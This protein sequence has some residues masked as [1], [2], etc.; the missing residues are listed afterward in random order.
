MKFWKSIIALGLFVSA[1]AWS[2]DADRYPLR[3]IDRPLI[4]PKKMW[5]ELLVQNTVIH[6]ENGSPIVDNDVLFGF[7]PYLPSY[8]ITDNLE[9]MYLPAPIFKY[10]LTHNNINPENGP[11]V[12]GLSV[13]VE[14]G[15][16]A[17][18]SSYEGTHFYSNFGVSAKKPTLHWL[19]WTGD[20]LAYCQDLNISSMEFVNGLGFQLTDRAYGKLDYGIGYLIKGGAQRLY[21]GENQFYQTGTIA[22]GENFTSNLSLNFKVSLVLGLYV[23]TINPGASLAFQW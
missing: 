17:L 8:S 7:L 20:M 19:W 6:V 21:Q 9:W 1:V 13:T 5:Q 22:F 10:L 4:L 11:I 2:R 15:L 23:I 14:G 3:E 12:T 18:V 16:S